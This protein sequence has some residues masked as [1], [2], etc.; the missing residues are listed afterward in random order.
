MEYGALIEYFLQWQTEVLGETPDLMLRC[1]PQI[2]RGFIYIYIYIYIP[3]SIESR[4]GEILRTRTQW[5]C[6]L[7][8]L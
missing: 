4:W 1:P 6:P 7:S 5:T 2:S 8:L 3:R